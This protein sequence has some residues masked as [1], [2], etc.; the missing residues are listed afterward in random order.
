VQ[1]YLEPIANFTETVHNFKFDVLLQI[2]KEPEVYDNETA[3]SGG[4]G[5]DTT[6]DKP[7]PVPAPRFNSTELIKVEKG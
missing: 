5:G 7:D 2:S 4:D 6:V 1:A 3:G